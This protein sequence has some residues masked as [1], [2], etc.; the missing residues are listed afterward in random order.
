MELAHDVA[1]LILDGFDRHYRLFREIGARAKQHF[2]R[3]EWPKIREA[4]RDRIGFYDRRVHETVH[5]I[6]TRFPEVRRL[7]KVWPRIKQAYISLLYDHKQPECAETFYNSVACRV[8]DRTYYSNEFIFTRPAISTEYIAGTAPSYRTYY[9][10]PEGLL[11]TLELLVGSFELETPFE[12]LRRDLRLAAR[13]LAAHF[14][15]PRTIEPDFHIQV[16]P[17]LFFRNQAAYIVG[18]AFNG[19][20]DYPFA[21]ALRHTVNAAGERRLYVD[22]LLLTREDIGRLFSLGR[23]Y[24]LVDME[25]PSAW[26]QFLQSLMP[27][28]SRAELYIAVGLQKQGKT[29][30]YRDLQQHLVHSSDRFQLAPGTRGMVMLVFVLPSYPYVF[31]VI[32]DWFDRPKES[33]EQHVREQYLRVKLT[34]RVGRMADTLEFSDVAFPLARFS[35]ELLAEIEQ[36]AKGKAEVQ[37]D[38]LVIKHLYVERRLAPLDIALRSASREA[39]RPIIEEFGRAIEELAIAGIFP[40]DMLLKNFGLTRWGRVVFYDYDEIAPLNDVC[41]RAMPTP[42]DDDEAMSAE[43]W[44]NVGPNDVFPEQFPN[45]LFPAGWQREL[46]ME[47]H[48]RL[49]DAAHWRGIQDVLRRG[50]DQPFFPYPDARRLQRRARGGSDARPTSL[51]PEGLGPDEAPVREATAPRAQADEA[52]PYESFLDADV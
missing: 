21:V 39:A 17:G 46:F 10:G 22:A 3:G 19:T 45:F 28:K 31:K 24:F 13:V 20:Q 43:P 33:T 8:L 49:A 51:P 15:P 52:P 2:E 1:R 6:H 34:D 38:Q 29:N 32:R 42:R 26:V 41:F 37:G 27:S 23:T 7:E 11:R 16:L 50:I 36:K 40:G 30:F 25:V 18:R 14:P 4:T 44:Y 9:L 47:L 35:P 12:D 5:A 48:G